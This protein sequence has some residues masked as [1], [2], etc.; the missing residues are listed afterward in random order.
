V[1]TKLCEQTSVPIQPRPQNPCS[2]PCDSAKCVP[3]DVCDG[4]PLEV[5]QSGGPVGPMPLGGWDGYMYTAGV[6]SSG[7]A[8]D[9]RTPAACSVSAVFV[10]LE[11][12]AG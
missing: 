3:C 4:G 9:D 1:L 2:Q 11:S 7:C 10:A 6:S 8:C 12:R 5:D